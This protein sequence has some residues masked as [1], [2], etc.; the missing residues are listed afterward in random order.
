MAPKTP[1]AVSDA[2]KKLSASEQV[3]VQTYIAQLKSNIEDL[4]TEVLQL[5][6]GDE[7]AHYHGHEKCTSDHSH[8]AHGHHDD[9]CED[10]ECGGHSHEHGHGHG[11]SH[12]HQEEEEDIP[13][14]KKGAMDADPNA[15]PFGGSWGAEASVDAT[16]D[17]KDEDFPPM[18]EGDGSNDDFD[19]ASDAKMAGSDLK[20]AGNF[21]EAIEKYTEAVLA[22]EPSALL[23]AN[24]A[25]CLFKLERYTAAIRDCDVALKKN[26]DSAKALRIRGECYLKTEEFRSARKDL[27]QAQT[28]DWDSEAAMMLKEATEKCSELDAEVVKKKLEEEEKLKKRAAEIKKA[29]EEARKEAEEEAKARASSSGMGGM[30]GMGGMGGM[31]GMGGGMEGMMAGLMSDPE[32]AEGLQNPKVQAAFQDLMGSGGPAGLMSNPGK[33]QEMMADPEVGPFLQ[34]LMGK[35]MGGGGMGGGMPGMGGMGGGSPFGGSGGGGDFDIPDIE[36][37]D[38]EMP[39]LVD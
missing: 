16:A 3:A 29:Q 8:S 23:L 26:P 4:E 34:K 18:Y 5:K 21:E 32:I 20:S 36:S 19:K 39:D 11:H 24:R 10:D 25:H 14:W 38:D 6:D 13:A 1:A 15:A 2:I 22:A 9:S 31:P 7:H 30:P 28:I 17:K 12:K 37:D 27:S 33:I 35:M